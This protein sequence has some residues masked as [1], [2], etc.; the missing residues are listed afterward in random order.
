MPSLHILDI[1]FDFS[2]QKQN[3]YPVVIQDELDLI[4]VDCGYPNFLQLIEE[5][6]IQR[7]IQFERITKLI[8]THH[9][10]DH[11]GSAADLQKKYPHIEIIAYESEYE[12]IDGTKKSM[13][14]IQAEESLNELTDENKTNAEQFIHFLKSIEPVHVNRILYRDEFLPWCGGI[15]VIH[16]PGHTPGHI[17]LY[18]PTSRTLIAGDAI[19]IENGKLNI[20]NPQFCL[21][22][23]EAIQTVQRL[24]GY[25]ISRLI[26]YHGGLFKGDV[27]KALD[28]LMNDYRSFVNAGTL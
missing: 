7:D 12:Y 9:D 16:T 1:E 28:Q 10:I 24:Q 14:L 20:A 15:N 19:V 23:K 18:I 5:A 17:S 21:N 6:A 3:I 27:K 25:E 8:L 4:L 2:G 22:L 11:I 26:C 13:R